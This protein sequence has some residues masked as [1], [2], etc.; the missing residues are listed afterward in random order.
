MKHCSMVPRLFHPVDHVTQDP[1]TA[2]AR[3]L[4]SDL[5]D[6][7]IHEW[8]H[9]PPPLVHGLVA[10]YHHG[11]EKVTATTEAALSR[12]VAAILHRLNESTK[13]NVTVS[14]LSWLLLQLNITF[15]ARLFRNNKEL[16]LPPGRCHW[17]QCRR[18]FGFRLLLLLL[19]CI[20]Y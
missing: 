17:R 1:V 18:T 12:V 13:R 3:N 4:T 19:Y 2:H 15:L 20:R 16:I 9:T 10:P 8:S 14:L 6:P 5:L 11:I 7:I